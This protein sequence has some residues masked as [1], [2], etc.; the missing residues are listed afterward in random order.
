MSNLQNCLFLTRIFVFDNL[1]KSVYREV[2]FELVLPPLFFAINAIANFIFTINAQ[3]LC[4]WKSMVTRIIS[5]I[6]PKSIRNK[7]KIFPN[8]S[9]Y[10][11][12]SKFKANVLQEENKWNAGRLISVKLPSRLCDI[13]VRFHGAAG[14]ALLTCDQGGVGGR[15]GRSVSQSVF[16]FCE[17]ERCPYGAG[18]MAQWYTASA[19]STLEHPAKPCWQESVNRLLFIWLWRRRWRRRVSPVNPL[20]TFWWAPLH[21]LYLVL[22]LEIYVCKSMK[23]IFKLYWQFN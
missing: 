20:C 13:T 10:Q 21:F 6:Y 1:N 2:K 15:R 12:C 23:H 11:R 16:G 14:G 18:A 17:R 3:L 7:H 4:L 5:Y 9:K 8:Y 19:T 22:Q